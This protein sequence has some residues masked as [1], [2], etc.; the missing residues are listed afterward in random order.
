MPQQYAFGVISR[1]HDTA[2]VIASHSKPD[3]AKT[4]MSLIEQDF[5]P[6]DEWYPPGS[7]F[8]HMPWHRR[9]LFGE[10]S[11]FAWSQ[12]L[13]MQLAAG[14]ETKKPVCFWCGLIGHTQ[15]DKFGKKCQNPKAKPGSAEARRITDVQERVDA[16]RRKKRRKG[17][18]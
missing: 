3:I 4:W 13:L 2:I 8:R 16:A 18:I 11:A 9:D 7:H 14:N 17:T 1:I 10:H 5:S 6:V 12:I 15:K